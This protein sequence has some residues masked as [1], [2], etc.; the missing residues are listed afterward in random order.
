MR[1]GALSNLCR[2]TCSWLTELLNLESKAGFDVTDAD[3]DFVKM[4]TAWEMLCQVKK[5]DVHVLAEVNI[6]IS[7]SRECIKFSPNV[8]D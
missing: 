3:P 2:S 1:G 7:S 4:G 5:M 8:E 6:Y